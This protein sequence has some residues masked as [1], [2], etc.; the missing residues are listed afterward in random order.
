MYKIGE[1]SKLSKIPVK[2]LRYYDSEGILQPDSI[3]PSTGYRYYNAAKLLDCY[4]I[5]A[6]KELG[7]RLDEIKEIFSLPKEKFAE[8]IKVKQQELCELRKQTEYRLSILSNLISTLKEDESMFDIV[9]RKSDEISLAYER[10][11]IAEK[12][13]CE[14][15][16]KELYDKIPKEI[17]GSRA[18]IID[19]ET[20]FISEN[21]D[22]GIGV[23]ITGGLPKTC[24]LSEKTISFPCDT[25]NLVCTGEEYED[26][27][28]A[29]GKYVLDNEYQ[30]VGPTYKI[31][32]QDGTV[33]VKLPVVKLGDF[34]LKYNEDINVPFVNDEE[35][36]GHWEM[37]DN[38]PCR[39]MFHPKKQKSALRKGFVKELYFLP[40]GERYWCF[41]WTKG[42]LL[43]V[44]GYP[45]RENRN[46]Y[47]IEKIGNDTY[48]FVEFKDNNYFRG[49]NPEIWVFR[50]TDAK[51]YSK[52]DIRIVDEIPNLPAEDLLVLGKW[53]VCDFVRTVD[54]FD[55]QKTCALLPYEGLY[56]RSAE[57]AEGGAMINGFL[58]TR[59]GSICADS[60][61][62]WRWVR[63]YVI[64]NPRSTANQYVI[65]K[66]GDTEYLFI[67]WKS[68]DYT[69]AG[70]E[71][72]WYVFRRAER[73]P[74]T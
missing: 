40:G 21:F 42:L 6:L 5:V 31:M 68:G 3:D 35:A 25:A 8:L 1:L 37:V 34:E 48:M 71:P 45:H 39:E 27:V 64:C 50:K 65:R 74:S 13:E 14:S 29:L 43:S 70:R 62:V 23:E 55:P 53:D 51:A 46:R 12:S 16:L 15:L 24:G 26:A 7:F 30:I 36:I 66:Y 72:D 44:C 67:Q 38:L 17:L 4:R 57:F 63:G 61:D 56:W 28:R 58:N 2:T 69:F 19:Y 9:I 18:V 54:T 49:G 59:D 41:A 32:Y 47:T 11:I 22:T 73:Q 52:Q 10:R 60:A 33:E 20:E